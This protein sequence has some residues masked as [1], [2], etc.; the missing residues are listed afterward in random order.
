MA[1]KQIVCYIITWH[2]MDVYQDTYML[3]YLS[4]FHIYSTFLLW[5]SE[6]QLILRIK[7]YLLAP[8]CKC[9]IH[10]NLISVHYKR[11]EV[12]K[13]YSWEDWGTGVKN[14]S[15]ETLQQHWDE[16]RNCWI[17]ALDLFIRP[18]HIPPS[19]YE[20]FFSIL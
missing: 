19:V 4:P 10:W 17:S 3:I 15:L 1:I 2:L 5:E 12:H 18:Y 8:S 16:N 13:I 7:N 14:K 9:F 11:I 20:Y 6:S